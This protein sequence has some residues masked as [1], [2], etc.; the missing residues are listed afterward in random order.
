L[1]ER[2]AKLNAQVATCDDL[3]REDAL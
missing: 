2:I 3:H 1:H